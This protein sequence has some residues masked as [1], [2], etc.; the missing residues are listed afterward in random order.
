MKYVITKNFCTVNNGGQT[1]LRILV[2]LDRS[3]SLDY[4]LEKG[5]ME[6]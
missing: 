6:S 1:L 4:T 5:A 3:T 2:T